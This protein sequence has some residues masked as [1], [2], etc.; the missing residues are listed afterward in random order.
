MAQGERADV[1]DDG[2]AVGT[3]DSV[4]AD[5]VTATDVGADNGDQ[6]VGGAADER[7]VGRAAE[8]DDRPR[9]TAG[10]GRDLAGPRID[11][12]DSSGG[13]FGDVERATGAHGAARATLKAGQQL[14]G[15]GRRGWG[16][17]VCCG[18]RDHPD[19]GRYQKQELSLGTHGDPPSAR[20]AADEGGYPRALD[21]RSCRVSAGQANAAPPRNHGRAGTAEQQDRR[22]AAGAD[23]C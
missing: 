6:R 15:G 8:A 5:N 13:G 23:R 17:G 9:Q 1:G 10:E 11:A 2:E 20:L 14:G 12:R 22:G 21:R 7:D 18:R 3:V 19:H 4:D 16:C